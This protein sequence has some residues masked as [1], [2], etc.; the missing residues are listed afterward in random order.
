VY[1]A[2]DIAQEHSSWVSSRPN[3]RS[4]GFIDP[5]CLQLQSIFQI[6]S[7][8]LSLY[9][10]LGDTLYQMQ[11]ALDSGLAPVG[12]V[13]AISLFGRCR[14]G[15]S[16]MASDLGTDM[17]YLVAWQ[18][19]SQLYCRSICTSRYLCWRDV[20]EF[21]IDI[22]NLNLVHK[23]KY[24]CKKTFELGPPESSRLV[25]F[26][27]LPPHLYPFLCYLFKI[28]SFLIC[29]YIMTQLARRNL[30]FHHDS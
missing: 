21:G 25:R 15:G 24:S 16:Q 30:S 28:L 5:I 3:P 26:R 7:W 17:H 18:S 10:K 9:W 8:R 19:L 22:P 1:F 13:I 23:R 29:R 4:A 20:F 27:R 12:I 11:R 6:R 14:R 2:L